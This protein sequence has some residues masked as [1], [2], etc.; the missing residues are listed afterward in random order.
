MNPVTEGVSGGQGLGTS[1]VAKNRVS[2]NCLAA[3]PVVEF[4]DPSRVIRARHIP[5][6]HGAWS[7][8][9]PFI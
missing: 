4:F 5:D 8:Q 9:G 7:P 1:G 6:S 2:G 3:T